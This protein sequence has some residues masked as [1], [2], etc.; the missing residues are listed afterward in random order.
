MKITPNEP[1]KCTFMGLPAEYMPRYNG[2][3]EV[4]IK[5]SDIPLD[6]HELSYVHKLNWKIEKWRAE[7]GEV[8]IVV[9]S[10]DIE[11]IQL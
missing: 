7:E 10:L 3:Y 9:D 11:E 6:G 4:R 5:R 2:G 1:S 8:K